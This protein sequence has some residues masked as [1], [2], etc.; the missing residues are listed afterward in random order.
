MVVYDVYLFSL[1]FH[2]HNGP[3]V[4]NSKIVMKSG[5]SHVRIRARFRAPRGAPVMAQL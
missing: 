1:Y 5:D 2:N 3:F 4:K